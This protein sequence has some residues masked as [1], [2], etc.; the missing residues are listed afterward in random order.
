MVEV[1]P[2]IN[3]KGADEEHQRTAE[4]NNVSIFRIINIKLNQI[5]ELFINLSV[6]LGYFWFLT[7]NMC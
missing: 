7:V 3:D 1:C 2:W 5:T 6:D 4:S